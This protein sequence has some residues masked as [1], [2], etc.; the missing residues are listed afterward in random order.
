MKTKFLVFADLHVDIMHDSVKRME[1][2]L[3]ALPD[4]LTW[5]FIWEVSRAATAKDENGTYLVTFAL[6]ECESFVLTNNE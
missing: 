6:S 5:D 1:Q 3:A 2:I 4:A